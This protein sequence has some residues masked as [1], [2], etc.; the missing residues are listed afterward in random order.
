MSG[1]I[2][3]RIYTEDKRRGMIVRAISKQF[4]NFTLQPIIGY[5]PAGKIYRARNRGCEGIR[6]QMA[7]GA[8]SRNKSASFRT[9][10]HLKRARQEDHR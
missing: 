5:L 4:E 10:D 8:Y 7:G 9:G 2:I 3:H 6:G 1:Q